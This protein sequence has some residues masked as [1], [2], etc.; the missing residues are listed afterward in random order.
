MAWLSTR[1]ARTVRQHVLGNQGGHVM[2]Y[3]PRG[4][5]KTAA[6][7]AAIE[8]L[9]AR[10]VTNELASTAVY[11]RCTDYKWLDEQVAEAVKDA[12]KDAR[13][14]VVRAD[15]DSYA[16][17]VTVVLDDVDALY[18]HTYNV[19][20]PLF[21][22]MFASWS[23]IMLLYA[24]DVI[25]DVVR[26]Y[27]A[28]K[29]V[30]SSLQW[31]A[32]PPP[33]VHVVALADSAAFVGGLAHGTLSGGFESSWGTRKFYDHIHRSGRVPLS[34]LHTVRL[35][36]GDPRD[37]DFAALKW[38][39]ADA[40]AQCVLLAQHGARLGGG[41]VPLPSF[42]ARQMREANHDL[43][44]QL[45]VG[46]R[47]LADGSWRSAL[48]PLAVNLRDTKVI[49]AIDTGALVL[50]SSADAVYPSSMCALLP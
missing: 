22:L 35:P 26:G 3:A 43:L 20:S 47:T 36:Y 25:Q 38:P 34:T 42:L 50:D 29:S 46:Q 32:A 15:G 27:P 37:M 28:S 31:L 23:F 44:H 14:D 18:E 10:R 12:T 1:L 48:R 5:G 8:E 9:K 33:N 41:A 30:R 40:E 2:L 19:D 4:S 11:V 45:Q 17:A 7:L 21:L 16:A 6:A 13:L 49:N 24:I 39:D